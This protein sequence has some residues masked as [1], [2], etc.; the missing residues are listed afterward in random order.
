MFNTQNIK[1]TFLQIFRQIKDFLLKPKSREFFIF[2]FFFFIASGFWFLQT[3]N[4]EY[5]TDFSIPLHL[6]NLPDNIVLTND[7]VSALS[8]RVRDKGIVLMN[9]K[10]S[11]KLPPIELDYSQLAKQ[12]QNHIQFS[13]VVLEKQ[14]L[15]KFNVSSKLLSIQPDSL[16]YIFAKG[17]G[18]RIPVSFRGKIE[19]S[20][21]YFVT[22][23]I[24]EP[25]SVSIYAPSALLNQV[26]TA[27]TEET[28]LLGLSDSTTIK[29]PLQY[30]KGVKFVP[31]YVILHLPTDIVTE[32]TVKVPLRGINFP[33]DKMLRTFPSYVEVTFQ[34]G[35]RSFN[36][37][38]EA[39]FA[40][41]ID[42]WDLRSLEGDT[43]QIKITKAP[44]QAK[45]VRVWPTNVDF[46]IE[47]KTTQTND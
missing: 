22:D 13:A 20:Q 11:R 40:I 29:I 15:S 17:K 33:Q 47:K 26:D 14:I 27:F 42:Y 46:L 36:T 44:S 38:S 31:N 2:L 5:D 4:E 34:I 39:D 12:K 10:L 16:E 9:Y 21:Q 41:N 37:I 23:T 3:L 18:K 1:K 43:Y 6:N 45:K 32:K 25:D 24:F 30:M 8:V 7:P 35:T 19:A 28:E